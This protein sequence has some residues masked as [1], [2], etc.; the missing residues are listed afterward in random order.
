MSGPVD[1]LSIAIRAYT[2]P[3]SRPPSS[4]SSIGP[5]FDRPI[6]VFDTECRVNATQQL[7]FGCW[8]VVHYGVMIDEGL[9]Y[10]DDLP[11]ADVALLQRYAATSQADTTPSEP[12]RLLTRS[13]FLAEVFWDPVGR[14]TGVVLRRRLFAGALGV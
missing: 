1:A 11:A 12:L 5:D 13:A 9:V 4:R 7:T 3:L 8:R 2:T 10:A 14:G 6:L